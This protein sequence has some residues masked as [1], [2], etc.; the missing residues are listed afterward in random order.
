MDRDDC[1]SILECNPID[2]HI[3]IKRTTFVPSFQRAWVQASQ[4]E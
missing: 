4:R 2:E 1:R 3:G